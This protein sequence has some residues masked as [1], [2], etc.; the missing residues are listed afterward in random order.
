MTTKNA[1]LTV[2]TIVSSYREFEQAARRSDISMAQYRLMLY[3]Q[4]GPKRASEIAAAAE[5]AKP[6]VS[7]AINGLREK[8]WVTTS[9][10]TDG[11]A[12]CVAITPSGRK[13]MKSFEG[14]LGARKQAVCHTVKMRGPF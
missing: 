12:S 1:I 10:D 14:E 2:R 9:P 3:L 6:T 5:I 4:N 13:R 7:L 8:G 11:R